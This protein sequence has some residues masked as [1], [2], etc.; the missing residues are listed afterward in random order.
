MKNKKIVKP[1]AI[2]FLVSCNYA[3]YFLLSECW[4]FRSKD[5]GLNI[6]IIGDCGP[7]FPASYYFA[8]WYHIMLK[9]KG[10]EK[11][12]WS[13]LENIF[14]L[15]IDQETDRSFSSQ[16]HL[17]T[18]LYLEMNSL[19]CRE[20]CRITV[21]DRGKSINNYFSNLDNYY[22]IALY[23]RRCTKQ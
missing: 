13:L 1:H 6:F 9:L 12:W 4:S 18:V 22:V 8:I 3:T 14:H 23:V 19:S 5:Q 15:T 17:C 21:L 7:S 2:D 20:C 16:T 11:G 10:L